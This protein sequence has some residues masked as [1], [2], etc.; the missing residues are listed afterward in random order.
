M[1]NQDN[2]LVTLSY[3]VGE[4]TVP[5]TGVDSRRDF[6]QSTLEEALR[7]YRWRFQQAIATVAVVGGVASLPSGIDMSHG[8][9]ATYVYGSTEL[10]LDEIAVEDRASYAPGSDVFYL[11]GDGSGSYVLRT[12]NTTASTLVLD[13]QRSAP[14]INA[15]VATLYPNKNT[16]ALGA[17][18]YLKLSQNP[19]ADISQDEQLFQKRLS[20]DIAAAQVPA[21]RRRRQ[22]AASRSGYRTG[23][24]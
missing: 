23:D 2:I 12:K 22:T 5:A 24:A 14:S 8:I 11:T 13:Y 16:L 10:P 15:S 4:R 18:R 9:N 19:D 3:L 7:A 6:I 17:R 21:P 20:E 1:F